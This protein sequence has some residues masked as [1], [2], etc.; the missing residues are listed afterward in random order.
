MDNEKNNITSNNINAM[1]DKYRDVKRYK[2][3]DIA[4]AA[5]MMILEKDLLYIEPLNKKGGTSRND[6]FHFV[7]R[8]SEDREKIVLNYST[9]NPDLKV[10]PNSFRSTMRYLKEMTKNWRQ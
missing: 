1:R 4:L 10:V 2:T 5:T 6:I 8:D 7:F 3:S 9:N